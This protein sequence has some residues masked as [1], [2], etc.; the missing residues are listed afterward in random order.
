MCESF[1]NP[2]LLQI[3]WKRKMTIPSLHDDAFKR[4]AISILVP[5]LEA[6]NGVGEQCAVWF[7][8]QHPDKSG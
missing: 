8:R 3:F 2:N 1:T 6:S 4:S 7:V 5:S